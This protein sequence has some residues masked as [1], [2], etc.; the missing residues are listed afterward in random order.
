MYRYMPEPGRF[1]WTRYDS[2]HNPLFVKERNERI[3]RKSVK[4]VSSK[5]IADEEGI[6]VR[7][8]QRILKDNGLSQTTERKKVSLVEEI[9]M[10]LKMGYS[11]SAIA[12]EKG[13]SRQWIHQI[14]KENGLK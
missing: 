11:I 10:M 1:R 9:R 13:K 8:V 5:E 3:C 2:S 6:T 4:G 14:I 7:H 12:R